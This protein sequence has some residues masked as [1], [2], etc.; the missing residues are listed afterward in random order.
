ME[1]DPFMRRRRY[2]AQFK[3]SFEVLFFHDFTWRNVNEN[4]IYANND[5]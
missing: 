2:R 3:V 5:L 4:D 1:M